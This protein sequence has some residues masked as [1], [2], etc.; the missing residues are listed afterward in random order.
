MSGEPLALIELNSVASGLRCI[1]VMVKKAPISILEANLIEPGHFLILF[2]GELACVEE[3]YREALE[4]YPSPQG[5]VLISTVHDG[6]MWGLRN[7]YM[8]KT[9]DEY[10]CLGVLEAK[11]ISDT[12]LCCDR[13]LK[14]AYV[15]IVGLRVTGG[16][17]GRGYFVL[18]GAQH[19]IE[20]AIDIA[21]QQ[22]DVYQKEIIARPHEEMVEWLF[23]PTPFLS[24]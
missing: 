3:S 8:Q 6:V 19:D 10:D 12:L 21:S 14:E 5:K 16:L 13:T 15:D 23:R 18:S 24:R 2:T 1:D 7:D 4:Y 11:T 20:V 22:A 9:A 17:G